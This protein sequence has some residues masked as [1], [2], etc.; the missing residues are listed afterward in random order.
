MPWSKNVSCSGCDYKQQLPP[1]PVYG[2]RSA[3]VA[4]VHL[5]ARV[6]WCQNCQAVTFAERLSPVEEVERTIAEES[7]RRVRRN[8]ERYRQLL[9][10]RRSP[11]R[12]LRCGR[13]DLVL[14]SQDEGHMLSHPACG[15]I[16][17]FL[18]DVLYLL[19][20]QTHLYTFEGEYLET[21]GIIHIPTV[22]D[23]YPPAGSRLAAATT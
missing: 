4:D 7:N 12:C 3:D 21:E 16:L 1:F 23:E 14:K 19:K 15:G 11:A 13:T 8:A 10:Q 9:S 17:S 5:A 18:V 2:Y 22:K 20:P 6:V